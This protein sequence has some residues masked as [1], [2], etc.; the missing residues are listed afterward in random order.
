MPPTTKDSL[1]IWLLASSVAFACCLAASAL[2]LIFAQR[3]VQYGLAQSLYYVLLVFVGL[4]A[5]AF[6]F[7]ALRSYGHY[8]GKILSG[9]LELGGPVVIVVVITLIGLTYASPVTTFNLVVRPHGPL[10]ES[11]FLRS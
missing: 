7:G 9:T 4:L 11:D 8:K 10:G 3:I 2:L 5:A 1:R 6:L